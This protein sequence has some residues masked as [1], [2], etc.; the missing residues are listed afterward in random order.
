M[1]KQKHTKQK[2]KNTFKQNNLG[3]VSW[4]HMSEMWDNQ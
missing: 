1:S 2:R 3:M 4:S